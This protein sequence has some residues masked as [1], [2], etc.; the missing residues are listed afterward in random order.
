[1]KLHANSHLLFPDTAH[2]S[3]ALPAPLSATRY[4]KQIA[5]GYRIPDISEK[6]KKNAGTEALDEMRRKMGQ[7][8]ADSNSLPQALK[9]RLPFC[10]SSTVLLLSYCLPLLHSRIHALKDAARRRTVKGSDRTG[11]WSYK[12]FDSVTF[13]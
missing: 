2:L 6:A 9:V 1:M 3:L 5:L 8:V 7:A 11:W 12:V 13:W 10:L 4:A